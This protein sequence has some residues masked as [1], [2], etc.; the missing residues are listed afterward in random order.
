MVQ[1]GPEGV[2]NQG[3]S[4]YWRFCGEYQRRLGQFMEFGRFEFLR[5]RRIFGRWRRIRK[6][7]TYR[8]SG[9]FP[10]LSVLLLFRFEIE[11][12]RNV[13]FSA[14]AARSKP[15]RRDI[16]IRCSLLSPMNLVSPSKMVPLITYKSVMSSPFF[17]VALSL[18][19]RSTTS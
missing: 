15:A 4:L 3:E 9:T 11:K 5:R 10:E 8:L 2:A 12:F 7:V 16:A 13:S 17:S 18:L 1:E 14:Q 19:Y 6:L